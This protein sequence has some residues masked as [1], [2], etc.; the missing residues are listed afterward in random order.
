EMTF[1][2]FGGLGYFAAIQLDKFVPLRAQR[3][4][5]AICLVALVIVIAAPPG[6][7]FSQRLFTRNGPVLLL[8]V[9]ACPL[10]FAVSRG[11]RYDSLIGELSYPMY[12]THLLVYKT[13]ESYAPYSLTDDGLTYVAG[14]IAFSAALLWL[15]VMPVD[16][17][18]RR[19]GARMPEAFVKA[20]AAQ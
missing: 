11:S 12:L 18:R 14:T 6:V 16:R 2:A 5:G 1:F 19:F 9:A 10:L 15:V 8:I 4:A 20:Q 7:A 17:Y 3:L 13:M